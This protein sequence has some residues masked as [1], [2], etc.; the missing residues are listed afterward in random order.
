MK[1]TVMGEAATSESVE[2]FKHKHGL[3]HINA[4]PKL[5]ESRVKKG[6]VLIVDTKADREDSEDVEQYYANESR[7]DRT[8]NRT[9]RF[10]RFSR[11]Y[12]DQL[13]S[14]ERVESIDEC[15]RKCRETPDECLTILKVGAALEV[16]SA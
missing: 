14:T 8:R 16:K 4:D 5:T 2:H 15:L 10:S 11:C 9:V 3:Q 6:L 1:T 7:L 12:C 13:D